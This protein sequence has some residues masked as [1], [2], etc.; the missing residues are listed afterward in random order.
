MDFERWSR[1][2]WNNS[3]SRNDLIIVVLCL[4]ILSERQN[5]FNMFGIL[6]QL[7]IASLI[8]L[9]VGTSSSHGDTSTLTNTIHTTSD[10]SFTSLTAPSQ[11]VTISTDTHSNS[12]TD[13]VSSCPSHFPNISSKTEF[14]QEIN[15]IHI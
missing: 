1:C 11:T 12:N 3:E 9:T 8:L 7:I 10:T 5:R 2:L 4:M 14:D 6:N 15:R 13:T